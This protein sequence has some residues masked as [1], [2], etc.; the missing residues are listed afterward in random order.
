M[1]SMALS[2]AGK[3]GA[4]GWRDDS[5]LAQIV[6]AT[7]A[8]AHRR[9]PGLGGREL[10]MTLVLPNRGRAI[11]ASLSGNRPIYPASVVKLFYMVA[12]QAWLEAEKLQ[13]TAELRKAL[14][15]MI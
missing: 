15:A 3:R 2:S 6:A 13:P 4:R 5:W 8:A 7:A 14:A 12:V 9:F 11:G 1:G 10:A